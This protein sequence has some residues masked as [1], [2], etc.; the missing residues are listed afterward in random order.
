MGKPLFDMVDSKLDKTYFI[1]TLFELIRVPTEVPLG[2]ETL[3]EPDHPKLVHYVQ[4]VLR[5]MLYQAGIFNLLEM[6]LNQLVVKMGSGKTDEALLIQAYTP[7]QH[8]NL[9][10]NPFTPR[11]GFAS[12]E[13]Y[14][15]HAVEEPC[16]FGQGVSQNKVHMAAMLT[17]L[18]ALA[19]TGAELD[20]ILYFG[21]NNEGK[22]SHHCSEAMIPRLR[23]KPKYGIILLGTGMSISAGNRGRVDIYV[24]VRGR[25]VHS[26]MP[27]EGL[28]AIE[29]ANEVINRIKKIKFTKQHPL[30]G[31]QHAIPYQVVYAPVA[32]HTLPE[33]AKLTIDRRLLPGDDIDTAVAEIREAIGD[34]APFE[35]TVERGVAMLPAMVEAES[36]IVRRL[37]E[38]NRRIRGIEPAIRY[39]PGTY[40]A[41]GPCAMG[42][43]TVMWGASGGA[44]LL[45]DD[46]VPLSA[47]WDE[48]R[49][50]THLITGWVGRES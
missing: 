7:S 31:G 35:V 45:G 1:E 4:D 8:A 2:P 47:A 41:G 32:P 11:I 13:K 40:D 24:H 26:S 12:A 18:K 39:R 21:I 29:G 10:A 36:P 14:G 20:G 15:T 22:S 19:D 50:L 44:G 27:W 30:L 5:P 43:P 9:T 33:Y 23:P 17:V 48:V 49:V 38:S 37:S 6:P 28:N 34:L 16:I 25:A 42:V 46:F 3:M